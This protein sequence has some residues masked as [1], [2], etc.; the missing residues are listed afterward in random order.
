MCPAQLLPSV[1]W[2]ESYVMT[3]E[4]TVRLGMEIPAVGRV[5]LSYILPIPNTA[6]IRLNPAAIA[7]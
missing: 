2:P 7:N 6:S 3:F 5:Q 1:N 4:L